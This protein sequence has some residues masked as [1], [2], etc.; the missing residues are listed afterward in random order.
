MTGYQIFVVKYLRKKE[1]GEEKKEEERE[2]EKARGDGEKGRAEG[3]RV[4][5]WHNLEIL[6]TVEAG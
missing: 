1:Q 5:A 6:M 4:P 3:G 2:G